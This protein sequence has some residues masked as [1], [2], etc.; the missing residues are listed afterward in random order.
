MSDLL[1]APTETAKENLLREGIN[2]DK[3][4]VT[5]NTV[6]DA[7]FMT[8]EK[9]KGIEPNFI[10]DIP[11]Q[12]LNNLSMKLILVTGHRRESFGKGFEGICNG[13][14]AIVE[15]NDDVEIIYPVHLNPNVREPVNKILG[16]IDRIHLIEPLDYAH[17]VWLMSQAY[18]ILT[19]SGGIQEEAPSLDKPVLVMREKTERTEAVKAGTAKLVGTDSKLIF[20]ET[21]KLLRNKNEYE[22]MARAVNPYGDARASQRIVK[23]ITDL[24]KVV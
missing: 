10:N 1:F 11:I 6:I 4:Y 2:E 23:A 8:L 14:K 9:I 19:D 24:A 20:Q 17:F 13:L 16:N 7:L 22:K 21:Q 15:E 12:S 3:I 5:G 18:L